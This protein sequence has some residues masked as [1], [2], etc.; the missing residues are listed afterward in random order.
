M[1]EDVIYTDYIQPVCLPTA[2]QNTENVFG[3][4]AGYGKNIIN[5]AHE[6]LPRHVEM[7]S[8]NLLQCLYSDKLFPHLASQRTFCAGGRNEVPCKGIF[9]IF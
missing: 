1:N 5:R 3:M 7:K 6:A 4:V 2:N 9:F 8:V